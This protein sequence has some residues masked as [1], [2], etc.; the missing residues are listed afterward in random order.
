[1]TRSATGLTYGGLIPFSLKVKLSF[2]ALSTYGSSLKLINSAFEGE[3]AE[4]PLY[5]LIM[6]SA[7][8]TTFGATPPL[9]V[10]VSGSFITL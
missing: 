3:S 1:M 7:T 2:I 8:G 5:G 4:Y 9:S 6:R 10:K